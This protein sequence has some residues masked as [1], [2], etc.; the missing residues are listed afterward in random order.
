MLFETFPNPELNS[1]TYSV[2]TAPNGDQ[3]FK[4]SLDLLYGFTLSVDMDT[5]FNTPQGEVRRENTFSNDP[6]FRPDNTTDGK[7][8]FE[9]FL[10]GELF[11]FNEL[12]FGDSA[13]FPYVTISDDREV[14]AIQGLS[15]NESLTE[16]EGFQLTQNGPQS[17]GYEF[18]ILEFNQLTNRF[19][20]EAIDRAYLEDAEIFENPEIIRSIPRGEGITERGSLEDDRIRTRGRDDR[21]VGLSGD[22]RLISRGGNDTIIAGRGNDLLR[23]GSGDDRLRGGSGNDLFDGG[24]GFDRLNGGAGND[25]FIVNSGTKIITT[26]SG[27]DLIRLGIGGYARITDFTGRDTLEVEGRLSFTKVNDNLGILVDGTLVG[28]FENYNFFAG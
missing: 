12:P 11:F 8:V 5:I 10:N 28:E 23:G 27:R 26:G 19:L 17:V 16:F 15:P 3:D 18:A 21:L 25:E 20:N 14:F 4:F 6:D 22:D 24:T 13:N 1:T 2:G 9:V 7:I